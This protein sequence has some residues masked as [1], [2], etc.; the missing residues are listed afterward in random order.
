[1]K[2]TR[3]FA[4]AL[5]ASTIAGSAIAADLPSRK[6]APVMAPP[7]VFTWTGFYVGLN[8]GGVFGG[9]NSVSTTAVPVFDAV[10]GGLS[11]GSSQAATFNAPA[12]NGNFLA[13]GQVGWNY[14]FSP[15]MLAGVEADIQG[16]F[17]GNKSASVMTVA[18]GG[19]A[20]PAGTVIQSATVRRSLD[21][22]GTVRGR[23]GFLPTPSFLLY[24]T[25]GL[26]YG[27]VSGGTS[28]AQAFVPAFGANPALAGAGSFSSTRLGW[29]VGAGAEWM[30]APRWSL[31]LEYAYYDLGSVSYSLP[32]LNQTGAVLNF[33]SVA[34]SRTRFDG[35]V[36]RAGVNYHFNWGSAPVVAKY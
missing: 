3:I 13:G 32:L 18:P 8:A 22:L 2:L 29:T 31:K 15:A 21:Y 23:L 26:A 10:A 28:I 7:P 14:Q 33:A 19:P 35:H 34:T 6:V 24:A 20:F 5:A 9:R 4:A 25:G 11:V 1:M 17:G 30:F 12:K 36:V 16:V 27:G